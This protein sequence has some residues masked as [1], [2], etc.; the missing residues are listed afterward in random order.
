MGIDSLRARAAILRI[1]VPVIATN[2]SLAMM[3]L[4]DGVIVG[5]LGV[6]ELAALTPAG[7]MV[8]LFATFGYALFSLVTTFAAQAVGKGKPAEAARYAWQAIYLSLALGALTVAVFYPLGDLI[9]AAFS[10]DPALRALEATYFKIGLL[11]IIPEFVATALSCYFVG[12]GRPWTVAWISIGSVVANALLS[13][14]LVFGKWGFPEL[15]FAG[16]PIGTLGATSLCAALLIGSFLGRRERSERGS[17]N[18]HFSYRRTG[19]L[20]K[21]GLPAGGQGALDTLSWGVALSWLASQLPDHHLAATSAI[22]RCLQ[23]SFLPAEG[24]GAAVVAKV[25]DSIGAGRHD[26]AE[27]YARSGFRITVGYMAAAGIALYLFRTPVIGLF[28]ASPEVV[29]SGAT[30]MLFACL[31]QPFDAMNINYLHALLGAGDTLWACLVNLALSLVVLVAGG[32]V[33]VNV[34]PH[35]GAA[36]IWALA[37]AY[38]ALQGTLFRW[39]WRTGRWQKVGNL[40]G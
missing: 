17:A 39:R 2:A 8:F 38:V 22:I 5:R 30:A 35:W 28:S 3:Q 32:L 12:V 20:L 11:G 21:I 4:T 15:G 1:A 29:A 34:F 36:G 16:A 9:F 40:V 31:F 37:A 25:G 13:V 26:E 18:F 7:I 19:R 6:Q 27:A 23:F 24:I 10:K 14:A 33:V